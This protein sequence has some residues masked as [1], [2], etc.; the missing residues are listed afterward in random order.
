MST[1]RTRHSTTFFLSLK[2]VSYLHFACFLVSWREC[3]VF[4]TTVKE[5]MIQK[6]EADALWEVLFL[7]PIDTDDPRGWGEVVLLKQLNRVWELWDLGEACLESTW[8]LS[9]KLF[10]HRFRWDPITD[11]LFDK[12]PERLGNPKTVS[13]PQGELGCGAEEFMWVLESVPTEG[14]MTSLFSFPPDKM[15]KEY[16][17]LKSMFHVFQV[18]FQTVW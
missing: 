8:P 3:V 1:E 13:S 5:E 4:I 7:L 9:Q 14:I 18:R 12:L 6:G 10:I 17:Y 15:S 16:K 2:L 11:K